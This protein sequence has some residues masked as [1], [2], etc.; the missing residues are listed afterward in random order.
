MTELCLSDAETDQM[1][2]PRR[3]SLPQPHA[4]PSF[5]PAWAPTGPDAAT[6]T[7]R[8]TA[9][10]TGR[11]TSASCNSVHDSAD[12]VD[13]MSDEAQDAHRYQEAAASDQTLGEFDRLAPA[14]MSASRQSVRRGHGSEDQQCSSPRCG[15]FQAAPAVNITITGACSC[16]SPGKMPSSTAA[17]EQAS[18]L[19]KQQSGAKLSTEASLAYLHQPAGNSSQ[20]G[21]HSNIGNAGTTCSSA[22]NPGAAEQEGGQEAAGECQSDQSGGG[23]IDTAAL[24]KEVTELRQQA[25]S[26]K[27][28]Y[29][30]LVTTNMLRA[31]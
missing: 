25:S 18:P 26:D 31:I 23:G 27:G 2:A 8:S 13:H 5:I 20:A 12:W 24:Q 29:W 21:D 22:V 30:V 17:H 11:F 1:L 19:T 3:Q 15:S 16:M 14:R 6:H 10:D 7:V 28:S 4:P 9:N